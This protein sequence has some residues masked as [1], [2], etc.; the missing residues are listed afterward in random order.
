[1]FSSKFISGTKEYCTFEKHVNA[2]Y[3]R[4][5]FRL[6]KKPDSAS[7]TLTSSGFYELFVN[8]QNI[9]K[10]PL[11]P[12]I[13]NPDSVLM[14]DTYDLAPYLEGGENVIGVILGNG[15]ANCIGGYIWDFEKVPYRHA[16]A[17]ALSFEA[18]CGDEK[19][20]FEAD[21]KFKTAE[22]PITFDDFRCGIHYDARLEKDGWCSRGFDDSSWISAVPAETPRGKKLASDTDLVVSPRTLTAKSITHGKRQE[23]KNPNAVRPDTI[24]ARKTAQYQ[25]PDNEEGYVY[26]FGENCTG[27]PCLK[28]H[29]KKGQKIDLQFSEFYRDGE[30]SCENIARFYPHGYCQRDVY[31]CKGDGEETYIPPFT[32]HGAQYCMVIG[33]D[34]EQATDELV[35]YKVIHS[36]LKTRGGFSCSDEVANKLQDATRRSD[37]SNFV[38]FPTDC[39]HRE[40]NG[41]T[42]D[43]AMS[44]EQMTLNFAPEKSYAEWMRLIRASQDISGAIA[45]IIPTG[46][47]GYSWGN[48]P[49]WDQV[50]VELPYQ[51]YK[52]RGDISLF[53]D[54]ADM[55]MRYL[56][57]ITTRRS[58][59]DGLVEFGLGDWVQPGRT[60]GNPDTP[61][62]VTDTITIV[63]ICRKASLLFKAAGMKAQGEFAENLMNEFRNAV[64]KHLVDLNTMTVL[65]NTQCGQAAGIYYDIFEPS[66][67]HVAFERLL[68]LVHRA[69]DH[70][71][72]GMLGVRILFHVLSDFGETELAYKLI[73]RTDAPSYGV[74]VTKLG[75]NTLPE[76]FHSTVD[77]EATSLNHHFLGDISNFFFTDVAGLC[78][79]PDADDVSFVK[80]K[81]SFIK[82]LDHA[83][84][85]YDTV[86]GKVSVKW[87]RQ[88]ESIFASVE[89]PQEIKVEL[90]LPNGYVTRDWD[91]NKS[92][93]NA[94]RSFNGRIEC[95]L[96]KDRRFFSAI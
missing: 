18:V 3:L 87:E 75:L 33:I 28:I 19:T 52:Y 42:G 49:V 92:C 93:K 79:N 1:M 73:T 7:V 12:Y 70:I 11:A 8:G 68:E 30:F 89:K 35:T 17:L 46:G 55:V 85:Y 57:Y 63:N 34:K 72:C 31:I 81:P 44:A 39:P 6:S 77:G 32:Y 38:Y 65:G 9:T 37:L 69:D 15:L 21:E 13:T 74:W 54:N 94:I 40:K 29:G 14:Y 22:S 60:S 36:D 20:A 4:R 90:V 86:F 95:V 2:P 82:G 56:H 5:S 24:K 67:K 23:I 51:T 76:T 83:E 53:K 10:S 48:G 64:R 25:V 62:V 43:A 96:Y 91:P 45:G 71:D 59:R 80:F 66:E 50:M 27:I 47:W 16:P 41:W 58:P 84:A 26:D 88:G 78:I 61:T